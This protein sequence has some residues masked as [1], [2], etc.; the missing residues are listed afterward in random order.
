MIDEEDGAEGIYLTVFDPRGGDDAPAHAIHEL[1][2]GMEEYPFVVERLTE[3]QKRLYDLQTFPKILRG[4]QRQVKAERDSRID[5]ASMATCPAKTHAPGRRPK[6]WGP[7]AWIPV[8][9]GGEI[10]Y[11]PIPPFDPGSMEVERM[12]IEQS[13][14]VIGLHPND[15]DS[16]T[17]KQFY[18][19]KVLSHFAKVLKMCEKM[20]RKFGDP[21]VKFRVTGFSDVFEYEA[22]AGGE[23]PDLII[24]YNVLNADPDTVEK[25]ITQLL[26]VAMQDKFGKIDQEALVEMVVNSI[27][28]VAAESIIRHKEQSSQIIIEETT[29]R[30]TKIYSG[31]EVEPSP[32]GAQV[33]LQIINKYLQEPDVAQRLQEDESFAK[34]IGNF[35]GKIQFQMQQAENAEIGKIGGTPAGFS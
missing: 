21:A 14:R 27:D 8:R 3:D 24:S 4:T 9:S 32:G 18:V 34:R 29:D 23:S 7:G 26:T 11:A 25:R 5:R 16:A 28:P 15:P 33:Q 19:D 35:H 6:Q 12:M 13:D 17:K 31:M 22:S 30:L 1:Q 20:H 10:G 2:S